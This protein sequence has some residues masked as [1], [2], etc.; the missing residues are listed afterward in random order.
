M[1]EYAVNTYPAKL[2]GALHTAH[3]YVSI[4]SSWDNLH[5]LKVT[6]QD[7][8]ITTWAIGL[9]KTWGQKEEPL[10]DLATTNKLILS[11]ETSNENIK[12][13]LFS[14]F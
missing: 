6:S 4:L 1:W 11:T 13:N 3:L 5:A 7:H 10:S 2:V 8:Y 14:F 9:E 12:I